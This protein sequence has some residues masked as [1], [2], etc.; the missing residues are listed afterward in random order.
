MLC[1]QDCSSQPGTEPGAPAVKVLSPSHWAARE[2]SVCV[3][4]YCPPC[5]RPWPRGLWRGSW[6]C[7]CHVG[8]NC[9]LLSPVRLFAAPCTAAR[10][11]PLS[12]GFSRQEHWSGLP[13][14][15]PGDLPKP[16]IEPMSS[17][18]P[19]LQ[20]DSLQLNHQGSPLVP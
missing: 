5:A 18:V 3:T 6:P 4:L 14:P 8:S 1:L 12:M 16:G 13:C 7:F 10:Q 9:Q 17:V 19:A 11:A 20:M 15:A 2:P